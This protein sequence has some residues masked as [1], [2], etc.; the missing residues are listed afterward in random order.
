MYTIDDVSVKQLTIPFIILFEIGWYVYTKG[1]GQAVNRESGVLPADSP[2]LLPF[3]PP[4]LLGQLVVILIIFHAVL[5][6]GP[7]SF[8]A[9]IL[10]KFLNTVYFVFLGYAL[11]GTKFFTL[12]VSDD[13]Q[14]FVGALLLTIGLGFVKL[15]A[16]FDQPQLYLHHERTSWYVCITHV[17]SNTRRQCTPWRLFA[18]PQN[19]RLVC[20]LAIVVS[21]IGW[22]VTISGRHVASPNIKGDVFMDCIVVYTPPVFYLAALLHA[23]SSGVVSRM[24]HVLASILST[25][26]TVS[27][28]YVIICGWEFLCCYKVVEPSAHRVLYGGSVSLISWTIVLILWPFYRPNRDQT[29]QN[30]MDGHSRSNTSTAEMP[31]SIP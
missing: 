8:L 6:P 11:V 20:G 19:V 13:V 23:G 27:M 22:M 1:L 31:T 30:S 9:G 17:C 14:M 29:Q 25:F 7:K 4:A 18:F 28:G 12:A 16:A 5:P 15:L 21:V 26:F 10:S 2:L 24:A 3:Y